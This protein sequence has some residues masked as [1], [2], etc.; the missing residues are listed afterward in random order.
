MKKQFKLHNLIYLIGSIVILVS[1]GCA[2]W[3]A[4]YGGSEVDAWITAIGG[5]AFGILLWGFSIVVN[6]AQIYIDKNK[7]ANG[8][9]QC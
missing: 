8:D 2:F 3:L 9:E 6:A 7:R 1:L 5:A 4:M